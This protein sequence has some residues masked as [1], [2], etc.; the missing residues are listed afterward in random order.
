MHSIHG[1]MSQYETQPSIQGAVSRC[2]MLSKYFPGDIYLLVLLLSESNCSEKEG[3]IS[4]CGLSTFRDRQVSGEVLFMAAMTLKKLCTTWYV[5]ILLFKG[6]AFE[7]PV[8]KRSRENT[9]T[10]QKKRNKL[11][12]TQFLKMFSFDSPNFFLLGFLT[13]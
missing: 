6:Y 10:P 2:F 12:R 1:R 3:S 8:Q 7:K 13:V 4:F 9:L 5:P 11:K